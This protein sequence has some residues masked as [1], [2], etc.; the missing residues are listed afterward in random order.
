VRL[1]DVGY[2]ALFDASADV[3]LSTTNE[4]QPA[5][6]ASPLYSAPERFKLAAD[7]CGK[8]SGC[9]LVRQA[10]YHMITGEQPFV[11][12]AGEPEIPPPAAAW[13]EFVSVPREQP[14]P[15]SRTPRPRWRISQ[16]H[17]LITKG[18]SPV[19]M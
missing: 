13:D 18:C 8:P 9:L 19:I 14:R 6:V 3:A 15:A 4:D 12:K 5:G 16:A 2:G 10:L 17:R 7:G 1:I 11:I